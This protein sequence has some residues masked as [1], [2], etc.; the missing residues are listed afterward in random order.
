[1]RTP[2]IRTF[3]DEEKEILRVLIV[4]E[5]SNTIT[6]HTFINSIDTVIEAKITPTSPISDW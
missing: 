1:M 6:C 5:E 3:K 2:F 4:S